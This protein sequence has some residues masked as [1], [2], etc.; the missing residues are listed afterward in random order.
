MLLTMNERRVLRFL[1]ANT[2]QDYSINELAR[3]CAL[4]PNGAYKLLTKLGK[5]GVLK[6]RPIANLTAYALDFENEKT[7]RVLE[8]AFISDA[9][10]G[11]VALRAEDLQPL[12]PVT[13]ACIVFGS[14]ITTKRSPGD[15]DVF[16]VLERKNFETYKF[17]LSRVQ[18]LTPV[19]IQDVVQTMEDLEE[20]I[21]KH[22]H[23]V[24]EALQKGIVLWGFDVLVRVIRNASR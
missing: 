10:Q 14:Y 4:T 11:R 5:E 9:F 22:D 24:G 19:K 6:S 12:R 21:K 17:L 13:K 23:I 1:A 2:G 3:L 8:I 16:F 7:A 15:L 20:N 18:D